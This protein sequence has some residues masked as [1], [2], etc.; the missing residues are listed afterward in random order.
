MH[1]LLEFIN[2]SKSSTSTT[3][4]DLFYE[5]IL[6]LSHDFISFPFIVEEKKNIY[7]QLQ[8]PKWF[9]FLTFQKIALNKLSDRVHTM[10][11][12]L[13]DAALLSVRPLN[14]IEQRKETT[15]FSNFD[16]EFSLAIFIL[17]YLF[18]VGYFPECSL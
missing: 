14:Y 17:L 13:Y 12:K 15:M 4:R 3:K 9:F 8:I 6:T 16:C 18:L 7:S 2:W 5:S 1:L 10:Y 11:G